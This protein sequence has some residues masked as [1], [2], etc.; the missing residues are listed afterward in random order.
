MAD[1]LEQFKQEL[2]QQTARQYEVFVRSQRQYVL[3][4]FWEFNREVIGWKD[5]NEP[6]HRPLCNFVQDNRAFKRL[7]LLPRGHLQSSV[8]TIGYSLWR[9]AQKPKIRILIA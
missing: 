5:L 8:V 1:Q 4:D 6:L 3:Q 9:I 7:I 2:L